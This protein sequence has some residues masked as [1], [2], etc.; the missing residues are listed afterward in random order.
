GSPSTHLYHTNS[1]RSVADAYGP[2]SPAALPTPE[3]PD[4]AL[5]CSTGAA[6]AGG[7]SGTG[8]GGSGV[9][10]PVASAPASTL[11]ESL[12]GSATERS[13][14]CWRLRSLLFLSRCALRVEDRLSLRTGR[15]SVLPGPAASTA[16]GSAWAGDSLTL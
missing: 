3:P 4:G 10:A 13:A 5:L 2:N 11:A 7:G 15:C 1:P 8:A 12:G 6:G 9:A 14:R 16:A